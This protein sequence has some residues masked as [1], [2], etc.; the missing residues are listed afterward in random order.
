LIRNFLLTFL[1]TGVTVAS[2]CSSA[3]AKEVVHLV[4]ASSFADPADIAAY[5]K[6]IKQGKTRKQALALGDD[7]VGKWGDD[8]TDESKPM[9]AL[10]PDD[11]RTKWGPGNKARGKKI[12]VGYKAKTI[13][14][15]L[16][17]T[18]PAKAKITNGAGIDLSPGAAKA[19][20]KRPPFMLKNVR[21]KWAE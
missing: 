9:C 2:V 21:W 15:E 18:M 20:G 11:W 19:F 7:G 13:V 12:A 1:L 5:R 10:P 4:N 6:A 16:R 3:G 17:D 14:C 8:T